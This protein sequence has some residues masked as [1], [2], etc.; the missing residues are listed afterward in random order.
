MRSIVPGAFLFMALL[1]PNIG[2]AQVFS[3]PTPAPEVTAANADWQIRGEPI[4]H[5]GSV[6]YPAGPAVFFDGKVMARTGVYNGIPLYAD[7]TLEPV[8]HRLR[9]DRPEPDAP[10]RAAPRG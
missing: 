4:F 8:Q 7:S 3:L 6:Y 1:M 2:R 5:A 10:L 9:A